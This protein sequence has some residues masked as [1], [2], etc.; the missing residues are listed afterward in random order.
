MQIVCLIHVLQC[1]LSTVTFV[2]ALGASQCNTSALNT[3]TGYY[4]ITKYGTTIRNVAKATNRGLCDIGRWNLMV[5]VDI[6]PNVGQSI[7]IPSQVCEPDND[8]CV[9][10]RQNATRTCINGGP[11]LYVFVDNMIDPEVQ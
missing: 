6:P 1:L 3:T 7:Y 11:R 5:D 10:Q 2:V 4:P 8:S 9:L